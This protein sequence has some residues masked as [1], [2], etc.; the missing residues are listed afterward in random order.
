[1]VASNSRNIVRRTLFVAGKI[2]TTGSNANNARRATY[3]GE[4]LT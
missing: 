1:M 3:D 2:T 4:G